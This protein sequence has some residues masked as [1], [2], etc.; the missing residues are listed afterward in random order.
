MSQTLF[1]APLEL[2][3]YLR[4]I[5]APVIRNALQRA[6]NRPAL[7]DSCIEAAL[8][9]QPS[10]VGIAGTARI[11]VCALYPQKPTQMHRPRRRGAQVAVS[12]AAGALH[13]TDAAGQLS[14]HK[15]RTAMPDADEIH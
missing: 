7:F 2:I 9:P 8:E 14:L 13:C 15:A 5:G 10:I 6:M 11:R 4:D 1:H 3:S 12:C